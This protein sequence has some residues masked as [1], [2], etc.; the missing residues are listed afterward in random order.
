[1]FICDYQIFICDDQNCVG[2]SSMTITLSFNVF[3]NDFTYLAS[4]VWSSTWAKSAPGGEGGDFMR[5]G[6]NFVINEIWGAI[7]VSRG[8]ISAG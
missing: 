2:D 3:I 4:E 1:M 6:G 7:S 8:A 5:C